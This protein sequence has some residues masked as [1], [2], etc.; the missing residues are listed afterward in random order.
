MADLRS[1]I[2]PFL[3]TIL[4][5]RISQSLQDN[6]SL[7][8]Y[9]R[10]SRDW[11]CCSN[12]RQLISITGS[13]SRS[14]HK[15][16]TLRASMPD[17]ERILATI[18]NSSS[19]VKSSSS[20]ESFVP[21][22]PSTSTVSIGTSSFFA[23]TDSSSCCSTTVVRPSS[24]A[25]AGMFPA[26]FFALPASPIALLKAM[27]N[28]LSAFRDGASLA[29]FLS[30]ASMTSSVMACSFPKFEL[31]VMYNFPSMLIKAFFSSSVPDVS[32]RQGIV[33][34]GRLT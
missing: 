6:V 12:A 17:N 11:D 5:P 29:V 34:R 33:S 4:I 18:H 22:V 32:F 19:S 13:L 25:G 9:V 20:K 1:G 16:R 30:M 14:G 28:L 23:R 2:C 8:I 24:S 10:S 26:P 31:A 7:P 27:C 3:C 15:R 21:M